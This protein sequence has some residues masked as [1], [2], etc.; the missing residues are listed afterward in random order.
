SRARWIPRIR[1]LIG[2]TQGL[3]GKEL[4]RRL[5]KQVSSL[6]AEMV[7]GHAVLRRDGRYFEIKAGNRTICAK[8]VILATGMK[9]INPQVENLDDL[10]RR[11]L[12]AYCPICDGYD[13]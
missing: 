2:Y 4:I 6:G 13:H 3:A 1:N 9:D 7:R 12:L 11:G 5:K 8:T 10:R